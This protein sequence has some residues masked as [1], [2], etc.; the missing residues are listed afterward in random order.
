MIR[1]RLIDHFGGVVSKLL[2]T[3]RGR[4]RTK[5]KSRAGWGVEPR[6][7]PAPGWGSNAGAGTAR[8]TDSSPALHAGVRRYLQARGGLVLEGALEAEDVDGGAPDGVGAL[9]T[10]GGPLIVFVKAL[11]A[12]VVDEGEEVGLTQTKRYEVGAGG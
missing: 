8:R 7:T 6:K 10:V 1:E 12:E 3:S 11:S 4:V 9:K 2:I 5:L